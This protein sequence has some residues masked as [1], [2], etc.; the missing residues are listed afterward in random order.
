MEFVDLAALTI[1]DVKNRLAILAGR[2]E[3][4]GD[5]QTLHE[6]LEAASTLSRLLLFYKSEKG[7]LDADIDARVP[8]DLL[9]EVTAE[10]GRRTSL[11]VEVATQIGRAHV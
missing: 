10:I 5:A 11:T 4:R 2:A 6:V 8:A 9:T 3:S 7:R 1:H